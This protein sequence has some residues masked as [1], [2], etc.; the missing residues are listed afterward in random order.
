EKKKTEVHVLKISELKNKKIFHVWMIIAIILLIL[1]IAGIIMLRYQVEGESDNNLPF[2]ISK[3]IVVS[4]AEGQEIEANDDTKWNF[5]VNQEN[6]IYIS[7]NKNEEYKRKASIKSLSFE[8]IN[9]Q[10]AEGTENIKLYRANDKG[11]IS[12]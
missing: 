9:I 2:E 6:D 11:E 5:S 10:K 1:I 8:N 3:M 4:T 12:E 7:I